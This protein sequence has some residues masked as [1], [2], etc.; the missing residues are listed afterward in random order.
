MTLWNKENKFSLNRTYLSTSRVIFSLHFLFLSSFKRKQKLKITVANF[1]EHKYVGKGD[2][3][4]NEDDVGR[5]WEK[6]ISTAFGSN[7]FD[8]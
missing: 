2:D 1:N 5:W 7:F 8:C 4:N 3:E 6:S